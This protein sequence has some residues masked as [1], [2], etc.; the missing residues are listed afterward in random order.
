MS[1]H[2]NFISGAAHIHSLL[3]LADDEGNPAP[4]YKETEESIE[5]CVRFVDS[6]I[7]GQSQHEDKEL[8]SLVSSLQ[9]HMH[10]FTCRKKHRTYKIGAKEG[11]GKDDGKKSGPE[12]KMQTCRFHFPRA[13]VRETTVVTP[14]DVEGEELKK[15]ERYHKK[16]RNFINRQTFVEYNGQ[17]TEARTRFMQLTFDE[18][19]EE[20]GL[21]EN[22]YLQG[23][24]ASVRKRG[25][26]VFL[27]R[28]PC[29]IF[30]NNFNPK[31]TLL[32]QANIDVTFITDEYGMFIRV[33]VS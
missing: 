26:Q 18:F 31:L 11:F 7:S 15:W 5:K 27:K 9:T 33:Q 23:L 21:S 28:N 30:T 4:Q 20:L 24:R 32:H 13:P 22:A 8:Q 14:P 16:I 3:W 6:V 25:V 10:T 19:L 29:D 12:L 17:V 1:V 2:I